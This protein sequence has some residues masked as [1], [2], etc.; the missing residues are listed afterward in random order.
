MG[1]RSVDEKIA[2]GEPPILTGRRDRMIK[3]CTHDV[4]K[5]RAKPKEPTVCTQCR[6][7]FHKG[8]WAWGPAP[9]NARE[10]LCP[11][12]H[13]INDHCPL[14]LVT[15]SGPFLTTHRG[16]LLGVV[17]NAEMTAKAEHPLS[18][19][20][21]IEDKG[22]EILVTTTDLHLPRRIGEALHRAYH[23]TLHLHYNE[24]AKLI[25]VSWDR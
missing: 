21:A 24:K 11:A 12:C 6:A 22:Q 14:G 8:R 17:H 20:I 18:R 13:R 19:V 1:S 2:T 3:E 15:L 16:D 5:A 23:G 25:R 10:T 9:A 7:V 4:C